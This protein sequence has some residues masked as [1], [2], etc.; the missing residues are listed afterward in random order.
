[1]TPRLQVVLCVSNS[2]LSLLLCCLE[3]RRCYVCTSA[4]TQRSS[5]LFFL[6]HLFVWLLRAAFGWWAACWYS[7]YCVSCC[8]AGVAVYLPRRPLTGNIEQMRKCVPQLCDFVPYHFSLRMRVCRLL[9]RKSFIPPTTSTIQMVTSEVEIQ[10]EVVI[11]PVWWGGRIR[12][13][14]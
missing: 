14:V 7:L 10:T 12:I 1:M 8:F 2:K 6:T 4:G 5:F 13:W 11:W 3:L 9:N